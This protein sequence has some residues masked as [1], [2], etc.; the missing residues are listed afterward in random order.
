LWDS[1]TPHHV[2][3]SFYDVEGFKAGARRRRRIFDDLEQE[4]VGDVAGK[5]LLH[6]QCHFGLDTITWAQRG[7]VVTGVDF[8]ARAI[9]AARK[10]AADMR[11]P[12]TFV[13]SDVYELP[14]NLGGQFDVVFTS[15][16]ALCWLP[17]LAPWAE[18]VAHFL[19]PGGR[20]H[21][22]EGHPFAMIFDDRCAGPELR[23]QYPYFQGP[24]PIRDE[25]DGTYAAPDAP[26]HSVEHVWIHPLA[27]LI[28]ALLRA[29][30]RLE[31]FAEYPYLAWQQ[32]PWMEQRADGA[33]QMPGGEASIPL[34]FS[35]CASK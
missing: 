8:S 20:V 5:T 4:L 34:M 1:W 7:A 17:D 12:A 2:A 10:L 29:G 15:H 30:L 16:G 18:V 26:L 25:R 9:E 13:H 35:L 19:A 23:V 28:G 11:I 32:F 6:L 31:A 3:S 21:V 24:E 33:W 22:I 14:R 27:D